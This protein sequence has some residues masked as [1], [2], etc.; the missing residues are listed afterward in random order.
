V[1]WEW[2]NVLDVLICLD[3][4]DAILLQRNRTREKNHGIKQNPDEWAA[5]FLA[6]SRKAQSEVIASMT[7]KQGTMKVTQIDTSPSLSE[8][9]QKIFDIL[10]EQKT[11]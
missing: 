11:N 7:E 6:C 4:P 1:S 2:A 10:E 9:V 8:T 3:S 5:E